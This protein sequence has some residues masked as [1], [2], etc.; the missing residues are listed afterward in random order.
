LPDLILCDIMLPDIDGYEV[1]QQL[2]QLISANLT[3]FIFITALSDRDNF[4]Y[5]MELGA[6]DYLTKPFS[7]DELLKAIDARLKRTHTTAHI[8]E[9]RL[10]SVEHTLAESF[11]NAEKK[12]KHGSGSHFSESV[13]GV[14]SKKERNKYE[15]IHVVETNEIVGKIKQNI[16]KELQSNCSPEQEKFL[17]QLEKGI[18]SPNLLW[19]NPS[20]F[21]M[22]FDEKYPSFFSQV[23]KNHPDLTRY[24]RILFAAIFM[25]LETHQLASLLSVSPDSVRKSRY[26]LKKKLG[27][28]GSDDLSDYI[29]SFDK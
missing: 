5:G 13:G 8:I 25:E 19:D 20:L 23:D 7:R 3:P 27:L 14:V 11:R 26:R 6:D 28:K 16:H 2:H 1:Y 12:E 15:I 22:K 17:L 29:L 21:L 24:E 18:E 9:Q 10:G 4:R